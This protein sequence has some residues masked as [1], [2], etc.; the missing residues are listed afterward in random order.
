[1]DE[2]ADGEINQPPENRN[3]QAHIS[4]QNRDENAEGNINQHPEPAADG[5]NPQ[6]H[7]SA[8]DNSVIIRQFISIN[9]TD[10]LMTF[11]ELESQLE[12][13]NSVDAETTPERSWIHNCECHIHST[14][15]RRT[16]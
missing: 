15:Q 5:L 11:H 8:L 13:K 9:N 2:N 12:E 3:K 4:N 14:Q 1:M 16:N 6:L 10:V 7:V